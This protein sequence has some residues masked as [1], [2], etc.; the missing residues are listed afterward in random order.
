M[1]MVMAMAEEQVIMRGPQH[2]AD[3]A[4]V[5]GTGALLTAAE[6]D[7]L[8]QE[9]ESL[10]TR[11]RTELAERLR[12]AREFG[13]AA[14]NDDLLAVLEDAAVAG[15]RIAQL[16]EAVRSAAIVEARLS[17]DGG[18]GLGSIVRV[19]DDADRTTDYELIGRRSAECGRH[20]VTPA[21]PVGKALLGA[22]PND[23]VRV[24]LPRGRD[25][26]LRVLDVTCRALV[27][28]GAPH[29]AARAAA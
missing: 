9:L 2:R 22:R 4:A 21:S 26:K 12:V 14:D 25:R 13:R 18:A 23:V 16:E 20:A 7:A 1:A 24:E 10:S 6:Y 11:H 3:G 29:E 15:A 5:A 17:S 28:Q 8:V 19:A 27:T